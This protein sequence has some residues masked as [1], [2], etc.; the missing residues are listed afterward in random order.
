MI[1]E[2]YEVI[3][4]VVV[5][6]KYAKYAISKEMRKGLEKGSLFQENSQMFNF[7]TFLFEE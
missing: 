2:L 7:H 5:S 4:W 1:R 3:F 6:R